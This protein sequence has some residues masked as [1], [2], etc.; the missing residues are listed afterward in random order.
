MVV[1]LIST[2]FCHDQ[3]PLI[4]SMQDKNKG[5]Q[6]DLVKAMQKA[7]QSDLAELTAVKKKLAEIS[8]SC[9]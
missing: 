5:L 1:L 6:D 7:H 8:K 4:Q 9:Q 2:L 3:T